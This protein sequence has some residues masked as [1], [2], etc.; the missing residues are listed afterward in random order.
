MNES[1]DAEEDY[2]LKFVEYDPEDFKEATEKY[3]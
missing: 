2:D 3:M 1:S